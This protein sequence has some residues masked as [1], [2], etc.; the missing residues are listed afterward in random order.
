MVFWMVWDGS[1]KILLSYKWTLVKINKVKHHCCC[2]AAKLC[3]TLLPHQAP[4]SMGFSR[5]ECWSGLPFLSPQEIIPTQ[6][7][8]LHPLHWQADPLPL[9]RQG[10]LQHHLTQGKRD[11]RET[12]SS[13]NKK[14][15]NWLKSVNNNQFYKP[16][17]C[18][19]PWPSKRCVFIHK[20]HIQKNSVVYSVCKALSGERKNCVIRE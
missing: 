1:M 4:L 6:G 16:T 18:C 8:N 14:T 20:N 17:T 10:N 5:Q 13:K 12:L 3:L 19:C 15:C 2:L 9:S 11:S 7:S